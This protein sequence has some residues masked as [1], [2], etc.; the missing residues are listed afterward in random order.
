MIDTLILSFR[1]IFRKGLRTSLT[2]LGIAVGVASVML[3]N[4]I[5]DIGIKTVNSELDSLGL[6]GISVSSDKSIITTD[7]LSI[8][9]EQKGVKDAMPILTT[10]STVTQ[11]DISLDV[12]LWGVDSGV[13]QVISIDML[14]GKSFSEYD[15]NSKAN[16]CLLDESAAQS[17]FKRQNAVGKSIN[18]KLGDT[19]EKFEIIGITKAGSGMLQSIM[20]NFIPNFCY[21]PYSTF[22]QSIGTNELY[23]VAVKLDN[24]SQA[25]AVSSKIKNAIDNEKGIKGSIK[26]GDLA[27]QRYTLSGLLDTVTIIFSVVGII[28]LLV[29]GLGIMTVMLVSVNERTREI[30]IKKAIGAGVGNI[31][32]EFLFEALTICVF[33]SIIGSIIGFAI[34]KIGGAIIGI[35]ISIMPL[36]IIVSFLSAVIIGVLFGLYPAYKAA[37][38]RPVDA[39]RYE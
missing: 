15:I 26:T 19:Y 22:Q 38:M 14:Y 28:S 13:K 23:Q 6:N 9:K 29:A 24:E 8:I 11:N 31:M 39:L 4:T 1:N 16:V 27:A 36:T 35:S 37:K 10:Q 25:A 12:M 30:G 5:S 32:S 17:I 20:G 21:I 7:D 33:G 2:I 3:I 18:I 34:I